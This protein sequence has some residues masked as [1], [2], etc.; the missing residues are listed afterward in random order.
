MLEKT[1]LH[2]E[3]YSR[4]PLEPT[5]GH[6]S[7]PCFTIRFGKFPAWTS[8]RW[9]RR[10]GIWNREEWKNDKEHLSGRIPRPTSLNLQML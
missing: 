9:L 6:P 3:L 2:P 10:H 4:K 1:P 7:L 5:I 8:A